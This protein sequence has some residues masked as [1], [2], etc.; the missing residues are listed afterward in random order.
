MDCSFFFDA[1][2]LCDPVQQAFNLMLFA[3]HL[4]IYLFLRSR[5]VACFVHTH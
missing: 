2:V 4:F 5:L 3:I 1:P